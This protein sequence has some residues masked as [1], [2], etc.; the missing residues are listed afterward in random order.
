M[1]VFNTEEFLTKWEEENPAVVIPPE[2]VDDLDKDW[3]LTEEEE[4]QIIAQY[5]SARE[6]N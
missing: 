5:F 3:I 6:N 4:E 2:V 1:P